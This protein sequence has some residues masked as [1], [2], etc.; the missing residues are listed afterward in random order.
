MPV[1]DVYNE[2]RPDTENS[3]KTIVNAFPSYITAEKTGEVLK[4]DELLKK[5]EVDFN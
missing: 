4:Q 3:D 1:R 2:S 5:G